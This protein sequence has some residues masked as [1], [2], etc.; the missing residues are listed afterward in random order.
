MAKWWLILSIFLFGCSSTN[1]KV[2]YQP[3][4]SV[5]GI[6]VFKV[7]EKKICN[8]N[9]N[10][11][12]I[13]KAK[14]TEEGYSQL[15]DGITAAA[16][17]VAI[18]LFFANPLIQ[19]LGNYGMMGAGAWIF[20][21]ILKIASASILPYVIFV[22]I[23]VGI[24]GILYWARKKGVDNWIKGFIKKKKNPQDDSKTS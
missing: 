17:C 6:G 22:V 14:L 8:C 13:V 4:A 24:I 19:K 20:S 18:S 5:G 21:G 2:L 16:V 9:K 7:S 23:A 12:E 1:K 10:S 11:T 15:S 3:V